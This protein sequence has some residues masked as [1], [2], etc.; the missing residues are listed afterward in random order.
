MQL[1]LEPVWSSFWPQIDFEAAAARLAGV[2]LPTPIVELPSPW[3]GIRVRGKMENRQLGRAFKARGAWNH[4]VQWG[5]DERARGVVAASSGNHGLALAWAAQKLGIACTLCMPAMTYPSKVEGC[6]A[7]GATVLLFDTRAEA[8]AECDRL[9]A[10]GTLRVHGYDAERTMEGA[11]T[12]GLEIAQTIEPVDLV[13]IPVG[14]GGLSSGTS[15]ALRRAWGSG[16]EI[17]GV[18]PEGAA[19]MSRALEA[20]HSVPLERIDSSIQGLT[21]PHA[22]ERCTQVNRE[23]LSGVVTLRDEL[24]L[25]GWKRLQAAGETV[26]PAGAAGYA[27]LL[28]PDGLFGPWVSGQTRDPLEVLVV[29]SGGNNPDPGV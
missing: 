5:A 12:I 8:E 26:E 10:Q 16:P 21:S 6:R 20:G 11:G 15:L 28:Q 17:W 29:V 27:A 3:P 25:D 23:T 2:I 7:A 19:G 18:E 4:L 14:G 1:E 9:A 13:L 22:G 24:I